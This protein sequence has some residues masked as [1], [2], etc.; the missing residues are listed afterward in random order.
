MALDQRNVATT[1]VSELA[2]GG[3]VRS[4]SDVRLKACWNHNFVLLDCKPRLN[5]SQ[6]EASNR[7]CLDQ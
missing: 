6:G 7:S 1:L 5:D 4:F 3:T 2:A